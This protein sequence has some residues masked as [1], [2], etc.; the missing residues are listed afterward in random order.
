MFVMLG[1]VSFKL[2]YI[3]YH[4]SGIGVVSRNGQ[5]CYCHSVASA[6]SIAC[7]KNAFEQSVMLDGLNSKCRTGGVIQ[8]IG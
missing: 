7:K 6:Q 4:F 8:T 2:L 5:I 3:F 1:F